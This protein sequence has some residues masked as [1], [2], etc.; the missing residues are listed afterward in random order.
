MLLSGPSLAFSGVIIW[1][2]FVF[3]KRLLS[4]K[5]YK[6]GVSAHFEKVS[7]QQF[8]VVLSGPSW[9]FLRRTKLGPDNNTYLDQMITPQNV[10]FIAFCGFGNAL[11]YLF[12]VFFEHQPK[13]GQKRAQKTITFIFCKH[14]LLKTVLLPPSWPKMVFI[15]TL[16]FFET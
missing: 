10:F 9:P 2:K 4:K 8:Q 3:S 15:L 16:V 13:F 7:A 12:T 11:K 14:R 6:I 1:S 5:H